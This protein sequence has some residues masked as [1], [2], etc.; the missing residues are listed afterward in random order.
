MRFLKKN[1]SQIK[2]IALK[3]KTKF[4]ILKKLKEVK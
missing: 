4:E 1:I 2:Q 3:K